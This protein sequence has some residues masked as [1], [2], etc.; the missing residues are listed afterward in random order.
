[1]SEFK[2][3]MLSIIT[4]L[5]ISIF[6]KIGWINVGILLVVLFTCFV[7]WLISENKK[8]KQDIEE[9]ELNKWL[10]RELQR[11]KVQ[12]KLRHLPPNDIDD[13]IN[14]IATGKVSWTNKDGKTTDLFDIEINIKSK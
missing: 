6:N 7:A 10:E 5:V 11:P 4:L 9:K 14:T 13:E 1:M 8:I 3:I 2:L 12:D